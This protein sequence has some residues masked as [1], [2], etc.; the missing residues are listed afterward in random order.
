MLS[1]ITIKNQITR[2]FLNLP[3]VQEMSEML[4][5]KILTSFVDKAPCIKSDRN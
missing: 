2:K 3:N 4:K 1:N 5:P